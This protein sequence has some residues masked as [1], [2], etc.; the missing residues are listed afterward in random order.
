MHEPT[1][2]LVRRGTHAA[3]SLRVFISS[4]LKG[5]HELANT[6]LD[7]DLGAGRERSLA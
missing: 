4:K 3:G 6:N 1:T 5:K 2:M 7:S